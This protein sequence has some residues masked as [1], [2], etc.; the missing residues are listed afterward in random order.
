MME[1]PDYSSQAYFPVSGLQQQ[2]NKYKDLDAL[3]TRSIA[4]AAT[5]DDTFTT[6]LAALIDLSQNRS[7]SAPSSTF[8]LSAAG[9]FPHSVSNRR[10]ATFIAHHLSL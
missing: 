5:T 4:A 8:T 3:T 7:L 2:R 9:D 6:S 1:V 10:D